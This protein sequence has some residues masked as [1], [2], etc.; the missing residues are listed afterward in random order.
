MTDYIRINR[1]TLDRL[2]F[3][4]RYREAGKII[5]QAKAAASAYQDEVVAEMLNSGM[6]G[7][8]VARLLGMSEARVSARKKNHELRNTP[9]A[10]E[11]YPVDGCR[12]CGRPEAA[13]GPIRTVDEW[14]NP[15]DDWLDDPA[16]PD[17]GHDFRE[18]TP[19]QVEGRRSQR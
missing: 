11:K 12:T 9:P 10:T 17:L 15:A 14:D 2:P 7:I 1:E 6:T 8:Q 19:E 16:L 13:H 3:E 5:S 18:P 4:D